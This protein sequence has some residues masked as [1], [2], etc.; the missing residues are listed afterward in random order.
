MQGA[1][2]RSLGREDPLKKEMATHFSTLAWKIPW[3]EEPGR[4]QSMGL[5]RVNQTRL[6]DITFFLTLKPVMPWFELLAG[7]GDY[8][9]KEG[10]LGRLRAAQPLPSQMPGREMPTPWAR[11]GEARAREARKRGYEDRGRTGLNSGKDLVKAGKKSMGA[12]RCLS[13]IY[14]G[15]G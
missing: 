12:P 10:L 3:M 6:S 5:Q 13:V 9:C 15:R 11:S 8:G 14:T 4:L 7:K 1:R 2:V